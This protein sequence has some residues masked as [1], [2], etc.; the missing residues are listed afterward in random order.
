MDAIRKAIAD[1]RARIPKALLEKA[2]INRFQGWN[3]PID[4]NIDAQ[5]ENLVI[6]Q[7]VLPDCDLL[8]GTQVVIPLRGLETSYPDSFTTVVRIPKTLTQGRSI[9]SVVTV[10][11]IS[12]SSLGAMA[13]ANGASGTAVST[14]PSRSTAI[15][16]AM[17]A[18][19]NAFDRIPITNTA[20]V[21]LIAENVIAV[22]DNLAVIGDSYLMCVLSNQ[23][24]MGN[25]NPR[26]IP[27]FS[28]LVLL[29][30]KAYIYNTLIIEV[31]TAE[32]QGGMQLG[33]FKNIL[34]TYSDADQ[35]YVDYRDHKW[36]K[37]A[38]M[39]DKVRWRNMV[40]M[41]VGGNR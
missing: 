12:P 29:A 4:N 25:I 33:V 1:V 36:K 21:E 41:A 3:S 18:L 8:G 39:N 7:R 38:L 30:A 13:Y 6:R 27:A 40:R 34:D 24:N 22:R 9:I 31:D 17:G 10:G 20:G 16:N 35:A 32:L 26:S 28:E 19:V 23:E 11:F 2:F 37:I 5:I 15:G 14:Y